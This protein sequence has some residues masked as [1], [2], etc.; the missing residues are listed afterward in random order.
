MRRDRPKAKAASSR[1]IRC[2]CIQFQMNSCEVPPGCP[3]FQV[4]GL[5]APLLAGL[6]L[7]QMLGL[8]VECWCFFAEARHPQNP[9]YQATC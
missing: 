2:L 5:A 8:L 3:A 4:P 9:Y 1:V 7:M 6:W